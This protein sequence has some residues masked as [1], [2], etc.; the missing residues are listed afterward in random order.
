MRNN[1]P[2]GVR[3]PAPA[4]PS[5]SALTAAALALPGL[6]QAQ[7]ET[8]YL[9]SRYEE[10][11]LPAGRTAGAT[12]ERYE[13][14]S[15][16]FR[17]AAPVGDQ[18]FIANLTYETLSGASPWYIMPGAGGPVVIMSG[19]SI[20][21]E[22]KDVQL[23]WALPLA[24]IDWGVSA[25]HS[26]EDDYRAT[27]A[28]LEFEYSP[29]NSAHTVSGGIG[30]SYDRIDPVRGASSPDVIEQADKDSFSAYGGISWVL[31]PQTVLQTAFSYGLHDGY[32]N[33]P[34]KQ[35]WIVER[36]NTV[37]DT[38]PGERHQFSASARLRHYLPQHKAA[39]HADYRYYYDSWDIE[40]HTVEL[41]WQQMLGESWRI[42]PGLR[43]YS[44][45]QADF[46]APYYQSLRGDG[47]ASSDYRLS[48]YGAISLRLDIRKAL[49]QD[50]EI[51]AGA[52]W[53]EAS[54][55]Y[56]IGSVK[57]E[58]PALVEYLIFSARIGKR[59]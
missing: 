36:S 52:E 11:D 20:R 49:A 41:S 47:R 39:L 22:R 38:R 1:E 19:A 16:L 2:S 34:Y 54:G 42:T 32:L 40:A 5:L 59:F 17:I 31:D 26:V 51:G 50:W 7:I 56:A 44:Q 10:A 37:R 45:S 8:D 6:A 9:Y 4:R 58:N 12:R 55:D 25:G 13:I 46:Y 30:Y 14:D 3:K 43:W 27:H 24:G 28:G 35:A 57:I 48:P 29:P 18:A 53:Y 33:D 21:E 15:H 23:T